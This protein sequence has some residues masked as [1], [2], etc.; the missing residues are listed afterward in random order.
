MND[1]KTECIQFGHNKQL[2]GE[3]QMLKHQIANAAMEFEHSI[4]YLGVELDRNLN[5][6]QFVKNKCKKVAPHLKAKY[7]KICPWCAQNNL[8]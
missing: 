8:K 3:M 2:A 5:M 1:S 7:Y 4:K 6:E